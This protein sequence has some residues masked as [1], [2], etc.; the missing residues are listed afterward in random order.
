M[1]PV[2]VVLFAFVSSAFGIS[3]FMVVGDWGGQSVAPY[4][5]EIQL[6][7]ASQMG[8]YGGTFTPDFIIAPGDNFY[9]DGIPTDVTDARFQATFEQ[10]YT[11]PS[12]Q[13]RW[14]MVMG[15]HDWIGNWTAEIA[16]TKVSQRWYSPALWYTEIINIPQTSA[17]AQFVFY[18]TQVFVDQY[19][20]ST[21]QT[22]LQ[23]IKQTLA[24]STA[25]WLFV[26]GHYPIWAVGGKGPTPL[27]EEY[28]QPMLREYQVDAYI[29]G[30]VHNI[31]H[32]KDNTTNLDYFISG[33]GHET[34]D[35]QKHIN[36][37]PPGSLQYFWPP[38][39]SV[40]DTT[41]AFMTVVLDDQTMTIEFIDDQGNNLYSVSKNRQ[42]NL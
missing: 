11:D 23:W 7:V 17:T 30:H 9:D 36:D 15:N 27:L 14:Y 1:K 33:A 32:L 5:T 38:S 37:V 29:C 3:K 22:Q 13:V 8:S 18:D 42:R 12:L 20:T 16:Y 2:I 4:T 24:T 19:G 21:S 40:A 31:E 35:H 26:I 6:Q 28:L 39:K 25:D 10:V 34:T 41:G